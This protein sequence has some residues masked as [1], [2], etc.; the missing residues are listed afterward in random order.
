[1]R[2]SLAG[3]RYRS[4]REAIGPQHS[5]ES[6]VGQNDFSFLPKRCHARIKVLLDI[7]VLLLQ[8][9]HSRLYLAISGIR[10]A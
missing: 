6:A 5:I 2:S 10:N 8:K 7:S 3:T 1:M 4:K 9:F